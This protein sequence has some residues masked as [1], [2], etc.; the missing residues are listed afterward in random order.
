MAHSKDFYKETDIDYG[1]LDKD[2]GRSFL[3][4]Y[5]I[6]KLM[7]NHPLSIEQEKCQFIV[8]SLKHSAR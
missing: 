4:A 1:E 6:S 8:S 7:N 2:G 5:D 3:L